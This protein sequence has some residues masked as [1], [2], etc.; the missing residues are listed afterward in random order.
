M[1]QPITLN[2]LRVGVAQMKS[3]SGNKER[4]VKRAVELVNRA[5][6]QGA[7][8]VVLPEF[9]NVEYFP[10]HRDYS[11]LDYAEPLD[12]PSLSAV[13]EVSKAR[14]LWAVGTVL[15]RD[16]AGFYYDT[17]VLFDPRGTVRGTYRKSHPAAVF[18]LEKI[19]FRYGSHMSVFDVGGWPVGIMICYDT[20]F[21]EVARTL[22]LKGAEL[23]LVPFAAPKHPIWRELHT[24]RAFE[25]GC[26]LAA[27]NK[28]G[29]EDEWDFSGE[30]LVVAP[31]GEILAIAS[32]Q[33]DDVL[34]AE[35]DR[36]L[37]EDWRRRYPMFRDRRPDLY[38]ALTDAT[39]NL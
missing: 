28:V 31:S 4:N 37:V 29:R 18:S 5:A 13:S 36:R 38:G 1:G 12:G 6:D 20:F 22:A 2:R 14:E 30:S 23:L 19:Y 10:Q 9:F 17:A 39:E 3:V 25:N 34:V 24:I 15:E 26:F 33:D 8:V 32:D 35:L 21:P 16:K 11:Y 27:C 7:N